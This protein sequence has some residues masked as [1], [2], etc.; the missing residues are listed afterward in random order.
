MPSP[1][2]AFSIGPLVAEPVSGIAYRQRRPLRGPPAALLILLHGVGGNVQ[3]LVALAAAAERNLHVVL[4]RGRLALGTAAFA[5]FHVTFGADGPRIDAAEANDSRLA[6]IRFVEN[7][8]A[9]HGVAP[10]RSVIAGFSQGG[11]LSASVALSAPDRVAGFGLLSGRI[12]PELEPAPAPQAKLAR[13]RAFVGHGRADDKLPAHSAT[14]SSE[15]LTTL[16]VPHT[17]RVYPNGH[18]LA[19]AMQQE[20]LQWSAAVTGCDAGAGGNAVRGSIANYLP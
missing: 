7:L 9:L 2:E 13:L 6:L 11:I 1:A 20:F 8:Q 4:P 17:L 14:R 3:N 12:L 18:E 16:G 15:W 5:W 19:P 10:R